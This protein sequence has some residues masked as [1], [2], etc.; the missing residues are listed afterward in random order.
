MVDKHLHGEV[1]RCGYN[2][3]LEE[4]ASCCS[5]GGRAAALSAALLSRLIDDGGAHP[6][7]ISELQLQTL[8]TQSGLPGIKR[9]KID[10]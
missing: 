4:S 7:I 8:T 2:D 10:F 3:R 9:I 6:N 1:E 5:A